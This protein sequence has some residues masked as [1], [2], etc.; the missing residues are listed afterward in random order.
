MSNI[1]KINPLAFIG[2]H[3]P[4]PETV[5]DASGWFETEYIEIK[6]PGLTE[7]TAQKEYIAWYMAQGWVTYK[8]EPG[9][10]SLPG[11]TATGISSG[12]A[13]STWYHIT[14]FMKRRKLQSERVLQSM[15]TDFTSAYNEG[16]SLN[17]TRY[18]EI[19]A[20]Y[21]TM[22]DKSEDEINSLSFTTADYEALIS[23]MTAGVT[24]YAADVDGMLDD[25]GA[26]QRARITTQ[27]DNES[28][29]ARQELVSRGLYNSTVWTSSSAGIELR[30]AEANNDLEDKI[31]L[32]LAASKEGVYDRKL[33]VQ[34]AILDALARLQALKKDIKFAPIELRNTI[35]SAMINFMERRTDEYPGLGDLAGIASQL[36]YGEGGT[37]APP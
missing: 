6:V 18:D 19:V 14:F 35:L 30:R 26:S 8:T 5:M 27:F 36:G 3:T 21:A 25:Y 20:I 13:S 17:N 11:F 16:R 7:A 10:T 2:D 31:L 22:L 32:R 28:A 29:K 9:S 34:M 37:V 33:R 23:A 4:V 15:I 1:T 24:A 12:L